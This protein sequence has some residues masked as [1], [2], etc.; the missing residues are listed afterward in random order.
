MVTGL[1][2]LTKA[3]KRDPFMRL[4]AKVAAL[5]LPCGDVLS[6]SDLTRLA[7]TRSLLSIDH[8]KWL[9]YPSRD[10]LYTP[11]YC[12]HRLAACA[13]CWHYN[14]LNVSLLLLVIKMAWSFIWIHDE[15]H[16]VSEKIAIVL[17]F[18]WRL[19]SILPFVF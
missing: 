3:F 14:L 6:T 5:N 18:V 12:K 13:M 19:N 7:M 1:K 4:F 11:L 2:A 9:C 10:W 8:L 15:W 17:N 16:S